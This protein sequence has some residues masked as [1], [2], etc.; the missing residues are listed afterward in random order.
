M[1]TGVG[2]G[3]WVLRFAAERPAVV[4]STPVVEVRMLFGSAAAA[5][6]MPVA[7]A[8]VRAPSRPDDET[9]LK[10]RPD[11]ELTAEDWAIAEPTL[12]VLES[13]TAGPDEPTPS[14]PQTVTT[15]APLASS[16]R[17]RR[18]GRAGEAVQVERVEAL[19]WGALRRLGRRPP[20]DDCRV[21]LHIKHTRPRRLCT[22]LVRFRRERAGSLRSRR[23]G[24]R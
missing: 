21:L 7:I 23:E 4:F 5:L 10:V 8:P 24:P 12:V 18:A 19:T 20:P 14:S 2:R 17:R 3:C 16:R 13:A 15:A 11:P 6:M 9:V 1:S 22:V